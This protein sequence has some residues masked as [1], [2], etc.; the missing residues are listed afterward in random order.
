ML[1]LLVWAA[2]SDFIALK[3]GAQKLNIYKLV[4]VLT[5]F[6]KLKTQVH[7]LDLGKLKSVHEGLIK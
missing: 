6:I 1:H 5:S 4:N 2:K 7:D 3:A